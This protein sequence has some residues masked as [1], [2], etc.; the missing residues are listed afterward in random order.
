MPGPAAWSRLITFW[1]AA[2]FLYDRLNFRRELIFRSFCCSLPEP[3]IFLE[4]DNNRCGRAVVS[5][6]G[7]L[8]AVPSAAHQFADVLP[9]F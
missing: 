8:M 2:A 5:Q 7:G 4:A 9:G 1:V 3:L 6:D